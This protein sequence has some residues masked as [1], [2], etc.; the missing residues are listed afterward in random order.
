MELGDHND[1]SQ[2]ESNIPS[3]RKHTHTRARTHARARARA[4]KRTRARTHAPRTPEKP[5]HQPYGTRRT[6]K[7]A[8][9]STH[10]RTHAHAH[11]R[12]QPGHPKTPAPAMAP[13]A[14]S[15]YE[16]V[17]H[18]RVD[19]NAWYPHDAG[20]L[21]RASSTEGVRGRTGV[22]QTLRKFAFGFEQAE[23]DAAPAHCA[24][25]RSASGEPASSLA[26]CLS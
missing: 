3:H 23:P 1:V 9:T 19:G 16:Q 6:L 14:P 10:A 20:T 2:S 12:T 18:T 26:S 11:A 15:S 7:H 22:D 21:D 4:H 25:E 5:P 17:R 24:G 8:R 13:D